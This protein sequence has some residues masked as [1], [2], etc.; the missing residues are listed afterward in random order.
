MVAL[1]IGDTQIAV[2]MAVEVTTIQIMEK[3]EAAAATT[4]T[5]SRVEITTT[6]DH[7]IRTLLMHMVIQVLMAAILLLPM[8][9]L[10]LMGDTLLHLPM[11]TQ[12]TIHRL[13]TPA[14][15]CLVPRS[16]RLLGRL[17]VLRS[18]ASQPLAKRIPVPRPMHRPRLPRAPSHPRTSLLQKIQ[19]QNL[20][21][22]I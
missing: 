15:R 3:I 9:M 14:N 10:V 6:V 4:V 18:R 1:Q 12:D 17:E 22:R 16:L 19:L 20:R 21:M 2:E 7:R 8:A 5:I 11:A 13:P